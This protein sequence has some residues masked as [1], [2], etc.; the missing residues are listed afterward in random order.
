MAHL[1]PRSL[2]HPRRAGLTAVLLAGATTV[3]TAAGGAGLAAQEAGQ[4]P[5]TL[6]VRTV[7][8]CTACHMGLDEPRLLEPARLFEADIH[9]QRGFTCVDCH[10]GKGPGG[11]VTRNPAAGFLARPERQRV[12]DMCGRCHS[13]ARFMRDYNPSIRVDQVQE[14]VESTHGRLLVENGDPDVATCV[15]CHPAHDI[16]PPSD[17]ESSVHPLNVAALCGSCH[18]DAALMEARGHQADELEAYLSSVHANLLYEEGDLSAPTCNDCHGNHGAAPPGV[19]SVGLVCGQCHSV[20]ADLFAA[21]GHLEAFV[22]RDLPGCATC[23][24]NHAIV[25]PTDADLLRV[26]DGVCTQCHAR[27]SPEQRVFGEADRLLDSLA[28]AA[29]HSLE[30]LERAHNVGIE[31][32]QAMFELEEV[33]N[34]VTKARSAIHAFTVDAVEVEAR[35]GFEIAD[36]AEERGIAALDEYRF[37]RIGLAVS[38]AIILL[39]IL[40]LSLRLKEMESRAAASASG[41]A[42]HA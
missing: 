20:M 11:A 6:E 15:S 29:A 28:V 36:K 9:S 8:A 42:T 13:D 1:P 23:H 41:K 27:G 38:A 39:L 4:E 22:E 5:D 26:A 25:P 34:S 16:R 2:R 31:V 24:G 35:A 17:S 14:Y 19:G 37:R 3:V 10:G 40:S 12:S 30:L 33:G 21:G 32:S 7:D 18:A